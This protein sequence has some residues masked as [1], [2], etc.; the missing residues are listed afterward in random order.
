MMYKSRTLALLTAASVLLA[1]VARVPGPSGAEVLVLDKTGTPGGLRRGDESQWLSAK[2]VVTANSFK[3]ERT[4]FEPVD[5]C[6]PVTGLANRRYRPL[7]HLS[8]T[9]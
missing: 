3:A 1:A 2:G 4:G 7:S 8:G 5:G 6:Y 9:C